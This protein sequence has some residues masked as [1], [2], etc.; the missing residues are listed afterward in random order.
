MAGSHMG[1][2][3]GAPPATMLAAALAAVAMASM[4]GRA[5]PRP[6][7]FSAMPPPGQAEKPGYTTILG[8]VSG[9]GSRNFTISA[10]PGIAEW[11]GCIGKGTAVL[12]RPHAVVA[13]CGNS[14]NG[15]AGGLTQPTLYRRGQKLTVHITA[16]ATVRWEFRIDGAPWTGS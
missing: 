2:R 15:F 5:S 16:P 3:L 10:R 14:G 9:S 1:I 13:L 8:P 4:T 6:P 11:L 12:T 7:Q